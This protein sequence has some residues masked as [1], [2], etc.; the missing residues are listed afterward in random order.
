MIEGLDCILAACIGMRL[1]LAK[2]KAEGFPAQASFPVSFIAS[3]V[4]D[5]C[6]ARKIRCCYAYATKPSILIA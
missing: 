4:Q 3:Y 5:R 6:S 1:L 2:A